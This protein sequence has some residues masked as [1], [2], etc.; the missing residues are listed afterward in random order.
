M[1][2]RVHY[3]FLYIYL[4]SKALLVLKRA[5]CVSVAGAVTRKAAETGTRPHRTRWSLTGRLCDSSSCARERGKVNGWVS[6]WLNGWV[7]ERMS[8]RMDEL[9]NKLVSSR[10]TRRPSWADLHLIAHSV[11]AG[12]ESVWV[13]EGRLSQ[14]PVH[15]GAVTTW[16]GFVQSQVVQSLEDHAGNTPN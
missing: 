9:V 1:W 6:D 8:R 13:A 2:L 10:C 3:L 15:W 12:G 7:T 11:G 14:V 16:I 5:F 4:F